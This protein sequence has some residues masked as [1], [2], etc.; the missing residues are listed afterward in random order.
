MIR[1]DFVEASTSRESLRFFPNSMFKFKKPELIAESY[2]VDYYVL[3]YPLLGYSMEAILECCLEVLWALSLS[4]DLPLL[5]SLY[6][7]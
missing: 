6:L 3:H 5:A 4:M 1:S 7:A 2:A